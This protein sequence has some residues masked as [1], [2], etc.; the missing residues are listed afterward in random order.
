MKKILLIIILAF[1]AANTTILYAASWGTTTQLNPFAYNLQ[2]SWN[3]ET[4]QLTVSFTL[5]APAVTST[6]YN[7]D[8]GIQLYAVDNEG[9][10]YVLYEVP[11]ADCQSAGVKTYTIDLSDGIGEGN[12]C[13][14]LPRNKELTWKAVVHGDNKT[15]TAPKQLLI[16]KDGVQT[17]QIKN[18]RFA[19]SVAVNNDPN[20]S[21]FGS[22]YV[23]GNAYYTG[24]TK[25]EYRGLTKYDPRFNNQGWYG[26][27]DG[28]NNKPHRVRV[29]DDGRIFVSSYGSS[30]SSAT[31]WEVSSNLNTWTTRISDGSTNHGL[32]VKGSGNNLKL[33]LYSHNGS[34]YICNEY[35]WNGSSFSTGAPVS[36]INKSTSFAVAGASRPHINIRY[37]NH[38]NGYWFAGSRAN[39]DDRQLAHIVEGGASCDVYYTSINHYA[40]AG[41][42]SYGNMLVKGHNNGHD[43]DNPTKLVF[44]TVSKDANNKVKLTVAYSEAKYVHSTC[45]GRCVNDFA[46][47]HAN[48]L[49]VV[50]T[51]N[52]VLSDGDHS[53]KSE[54]GQLMAFA[55]PY[56]GNT[57]T[58]A[59]N[60]AAHKFTLRCDE[61]QSYSVNL[62]ANDASMGTAT[63][64]AGTGLNDGYKACS[65]VTIKA[66]SNG[67]YRFVNWTKNEVEVSK[68]STYT[69]TV[70]DD[71]TIQANFAVN[72]FDIEWYNLF[73]NHQDITDYITN[74]NSSMDG[75]V[76]SRLYRL[77]QVQ[78]NEYFGLSITSNKFIT[79]TET[80]KSVFHVLAFL[81]NQKTNTTTFMTNSNSPFYWLGEYIKTTI[82]EDIEDNTYEWPYLL[83]LFF[84]R[85]NKPYS[86]NGTYVGEYDV[87]KVYFKNNVIPDFSETGKPTHWRTWWTKYACELPTTQ[88]YETNLPKNW[89]KHTPPTGSIAGLKPSAWYQWNSDTA[90]V[91][92]GKLLAWYYDNPEAPT[93]PENPTIVRNV[94]QDG[95]L[96]ATWVDKLISEERT[97][98]NNSDAIW[99]LNYYGE[100]THNIKIERKMRANMYNTLCLPFS[101]TKSQQPTVLQNATI[102]K[103]SGINED[104]YDE[105]GEPVVELQFTQVTD[106]EAGVPYLVMPKEDISGEITFTGITTG[107]N[108]EQPIVI[109]EAATVTQP[110]TNG[111]VSFIGNIH[112]TNIPVHSLIVV[113]DNRLAEVT[114]A[115]DM[116]AMRAHFYINDASL[117]TLADQGRVYLSMRKPVT[118]DVPLAPEAEKP[119]VSKARKILHNGQIYIIR[120]NATYT[121]TGARVR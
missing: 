31:V 62:V 108:N 22:I 118:T 49:Y 99:L 75:A 44:Y 27:Y 19:T 50:S 105:S 89:N 102:M 33:L 112:T 73:Q 4:Q 66:Q 92:Q 10:S 11:A 36:A 54:T 7:N 79:E 37:D 109:E 52:S 121:I 30:T 59:P 21:D 29:S 6:T 68:D 67:G 65:D 60:T 77:F 84:N 107:Y 28:N 120:D 72:V 5:N 61:N 82:D 81:D 41:V 51:Q 48:N 12:S 20:S 3:E 35:T 94:Y 8:L 83:H 43:T 95:A 56:S 76:N 97:D 14:Q 26:I 74:P 104:L 64:I 55:L 9:N 58:P 103:F 111:S 57:T 110:T 86:I 45:K 40:G 39:S 63:I 87:V 88:T 78:F 17:G 117:Q 34:N 69:F 13:V 93:W 98:Q 106:I 42:L 113:A 119:E 15:L 80:G 46:I 1:F 100:S 32:D 16:T 2:T 23:A 47:D 38:Y 24:E 53:I 116:D 18:W 25:I 91:N 114:K 70:I 71:V 96:F 90:E 101:A 85:T 115:G